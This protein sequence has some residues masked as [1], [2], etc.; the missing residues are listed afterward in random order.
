[1]KTGYVKKSAV[2]KKGGGKSFESRGFV[3]LQMTK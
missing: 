2:G 1:M 3:T